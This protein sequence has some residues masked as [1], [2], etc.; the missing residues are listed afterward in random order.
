MLE[1]G[2]GAAVV[3][4][5][6]WLLWRPWWAGRATFEGLLASGTAQPSPSPGSWFPQPALA[7][8]LALTVLALSWFRPLP[9]AAAGWAV[10]ALV[11]LA[12]LPV[13]WPWY[14]G[15][16]VAVLLLR[17][18]AVALAQVVALTAGSRIAGP[19]G[20]LAALGLVDFPT[21]FARDALWGIT[22][23]VAACAV[24][25]LVGVVGRALRSGRA[26]RPS[27]PG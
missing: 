5:L 26:A 10:I 14:A 8:A 23:P 1:L 22:L 21:M 7:G 18:T 16:A 4:G 13:Y 9:R 6:T 24:L 12:V 25:G 11:A 3:A 17:P 27:V 19:Y 2:I 15:L 20:D